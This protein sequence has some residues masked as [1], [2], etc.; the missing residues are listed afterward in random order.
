MRMREWHNDQSW[1]D[2]AQYTLMLQCISTRVKTVLRSLV[3][4]VFKYHVFSHE[5]AYSLPTHHQFSHLR[6][7]EVGLAPPMCKKLFG[8]Y[9]TERLS[10]ASDDRSVSC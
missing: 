5:P 7:V 4:F 1:L 6:Q 9:H 3:I 2:V 10:R 8:Y